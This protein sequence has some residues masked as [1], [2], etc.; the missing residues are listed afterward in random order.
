MSRQGSCAPVERLA[1]LAGFMQ[2]H[3][4]LAGSGPDPVGQGEMREH[5][6]P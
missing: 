6:L 1:R 5:F 4:E 2:R 3:L